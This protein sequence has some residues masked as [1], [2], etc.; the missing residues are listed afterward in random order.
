[1][2]TLPLHA[3]AAGLAERGIPSRMLGAR[4]PV[5][6]LVAAVRRSGPPAVMIW[7][8]DD[9]TG[10]PAVLTA[11]PSLRPAPFLAV[12]GPGW[13]AELPHG[14][15]RVT[16]LTDAVTRLSGAVRGLG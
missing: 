14:V 13:P 4:L 15:T 16:D 10:D 8:H 9:I 6:A 11:V 5:D 3:V 12:G 1:M 2:H 7:S